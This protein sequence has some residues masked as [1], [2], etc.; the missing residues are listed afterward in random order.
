[1]ITTTIGHYPRIGDR[2]EQQKLR[3]AIQAHQAQSLTD[4]DLKA[5]QDE[6]TAEVIGEQTA[7]GLNQVTDG[8]IRWDDPQTYLCLKLDGFERGG[9]IR[10]FD[11]NTYYRQPI[12]VR[13]VSWKAPILV[14][15]FKFAKSKSTVPVRTVLTGAYTLARLSADKY[16]NDVAAFTEDLA[17]ALNEEVR[18]LVAAG[19]RIIQIDEPALTLHPQDEKIVAKALVQTFDGIGSSSGVERHAWLYNG[20]Q[21]ALVDKAA[22]WR[23]D[24]VGFDVISDPKLLDRIAAIGFPKILGLGVVNARNTKLEGVLEIHRVLDR[25]SQTVGLE[26]VMITPSCG[27]EFLPRDRAQRKIA[28]LVEAARSYRGGGR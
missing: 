7:A 2:P 6:V 3:R 8:Q 1:M 25:V 21:A 13:R 22:G 9:M 12:A 28:R 5:V 23:V 4:A 10:Y 24:A 17:K 14:D 18:A 20:P 27:L 11:T 26:R 19:A 15:D 16:Y